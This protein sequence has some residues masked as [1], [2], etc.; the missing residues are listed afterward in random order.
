MKN[1]FCSQQGLVARGLITLA[2]AFSSLFALA[3]DDK[4]N[5][6]VIM[7]DNLGYG[8]VGVYGG[9][10]APTPVIDQ[11]ARDGV[12]LRDFQVEPTG[13]ES[14]AAFMTGRMPIRSGISYAA[15]VGNARGLHPKEVTIAELMKRADYNTALFGKWQLG[16][17]PKRQPQMQGFDQ[18]YGILETS[19]PIDPSFPGFSKKLIQKQ[20]ILSAKAEEE[21]KLTG[22]MTYVQRSYMDRELTEKG[23]TFIKE[24]VE[25]K[26]PFFLMI[27]YL[28][29]HYP[30]VPHPDFA[31][32]SLGGAYTD[33][34]MEMD[35]NTGKVLAALNEV[36]I[37]ENT[38]VIW[39]S[40]NG[41]SRQSPEA[42]HNGDPGPWS[43]ESGSAWEGG[44]RTVAIIRWPASVKAGWVS[45][46]M[47]HVMDL[48][49]TLGQIAGAEIPDDRPIDGVDQR[50]Y[51]SGE[52]SHSQ[53]D[54]R[55]VFYQ[56]KLTAIRWRQFK[57]HLVVYERFRSMS[58]PGRDLSRRPQIYNL[59]TD[60]KELYDLAGR[61]G[62]NS[63]L[64]TLLKVAEPY[65]ASFREFPN[66][67]YKNFDRRD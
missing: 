1:F 54:H 15:S 62:G 46:E 49:T 34:L 27:S 8:D 67:E 23:I 43:G 64:A 41:P 35:F 58:T 36:G 65:Q 59:K 33:V 60:P 12:Q 42:D 39:F 38:I 51:L 4:P 20:Q 24:Q 9:M 13:P 3:A 61:S 48:Y 14:R 19:S 29:P 66:N 45:D 25:A 55:M 44:L 31:G 11:L 16:S 6:V 28:N 52:K 32:K 53:R 37:R 18:F 21:A 5:I 63:M 40:D 26:T 50:A 10:R 30:V 57:A 7:A 17:T 22:E 2:I 47:V 56:N